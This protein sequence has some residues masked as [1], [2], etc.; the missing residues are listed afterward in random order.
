MS[1]M[2]VRCAFYFGMFGGE[3]SNL[4]Q[5]DPCIFQLKMVSFGF[6]PLPLYYW[7][8]SFNDLEFSAFSRLLW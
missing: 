2:A 7:L 1:L 6:A 4:T 8:F 3:D 5:N